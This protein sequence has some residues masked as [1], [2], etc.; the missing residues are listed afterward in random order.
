MK[1]LLLDP[2]LFNYLIITLYCCAVIRW[3]LERSWANAF[4]WL[5]AAGITATV[6]W[7]LKAH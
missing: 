4:Y 5:C 6:T 2:R 1:A 3:S 7:G